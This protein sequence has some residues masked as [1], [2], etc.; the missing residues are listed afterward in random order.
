[1]ARAADVNHS[2]R[3]KLRHAASRTADRPLRA[4]TALEVEKGGKQTDAGT[5]GRLAYRVEGVIRCRC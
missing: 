5:A 3:V 2:K 4:E 1:M